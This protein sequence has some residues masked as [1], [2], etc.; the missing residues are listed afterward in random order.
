MVIIVL[1]AIVILIFILLFINKIYIDFRSF[2]AKTLPLD[3]GVF[4]VYCFEGKQGS[5]KTYALTKY[6]IRNGTNKTIYSNMTLKNIDYKPIRDLKHLLSLRDEQNVFIV[7]D[8]I[9]NLLNDR[10]IPRDIRDELFEFLT[11]QR[12]MKNILFTTTQEWLSIPIEF[13]RFVRIQIICTTIPLGK[14]GG[15]LRQEFCD[16]YQMKWSQIDNEYIAPR[17]SLK[18]SKYEKRIMLSYDTYERVR[19][20]ARAEPPTQLKRAPTTLK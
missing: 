18:F 13:R 16:A 14:F 12:K 11:Q 9:L 20:L 15:I 2:L 10:S 17:I 8:E 7:Y 19:K 3:R 6:L 1:A 4:G 5:G